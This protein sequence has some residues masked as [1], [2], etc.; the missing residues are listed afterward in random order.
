MNEIKLEGD[1]KSAIA[2]KIRQLRKCMCAIPTPPL[3][4]SSQLV[5]AMC[6]FS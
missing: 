4:A 2:S 1:G 6:F 5:T 3:T